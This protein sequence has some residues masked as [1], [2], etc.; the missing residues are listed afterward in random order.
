MTEQITLIL[1]TEVE[2]HPVI[3]PIETIFH[4]TDV[5]LHLEMALKMVNVLLLH[6]IPA[7]DLITIKET[8]DLIVHLTDPRN[9]HHT[10][11]TLVTGL[12]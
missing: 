7:Q 3:T 10:D 4:K 12:L 8:L 9:D 5:A 1:N 11:V 2:V 6:I